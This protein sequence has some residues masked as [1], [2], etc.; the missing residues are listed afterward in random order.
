MQNSA[1]FWE[2][3]Y[4]TGFFVFI[5]MLPW[6]PALYDY[7]MIWGT[8]GL[9]GDRAA[10]MRSVRI[11]DG[12]VSGPWIGGW[13]AILWSFFPV[14]LVFI[15]ASLFEGGVDHTPGYVPLDLDSGVAKGQAPR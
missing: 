10:R 12:T 13:R 5:L 4:D 14:Y 2:L 9:F 6:F 7:G 8:W 15:I 11:T 1:D 3:G